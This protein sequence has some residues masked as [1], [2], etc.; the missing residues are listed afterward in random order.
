MASAAKPPAITPTI[1]SVLLLLPELVLLLLALEVVLVLLELDC[2]L[3]EVVALGVLEGDVLDND[4]LVLVGVG[5][6]V[7]LGGVALAD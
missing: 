1:E 3:E 5:A 2:W 7:V 6:E 4:G